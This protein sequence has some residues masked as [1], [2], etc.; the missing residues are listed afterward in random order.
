MNLLRVCVLCFKGKPEA[1]GNYLY[2][3]DYDQTILKE[4]SEAAVTAVLH[5]PIPDDMLMLYDGENWAEFCGMLID[6]VIDTGATM[7]EMQQCI[8]DLTPLPGTSCYSRKHERN[9]GLLN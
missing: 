3:F 2:A 4:D 1:T 8:R 7:Q 9:K 5:S 6:Y